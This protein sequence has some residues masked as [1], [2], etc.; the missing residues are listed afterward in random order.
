MKKIT[1]ITIGSLVFAIEDDAYGKLTEYLKAIEVAFAGNDD[2]TEIAAD[3]APDTAKDS[4]K[5]DSAKNR[6]VK[7]RMRVLFIYC[8]P[9]FAQY[10]CVCVT[11]AACA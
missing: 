9:R 10:Y 2:Y 3:I 6:T 8:S 11:V 4:P 7:N 5:P 1:N